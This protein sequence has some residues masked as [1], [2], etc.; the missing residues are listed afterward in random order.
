[1]VRVQVLFVLL[2]LSVAGTARAADPTLSPAKRAEARE[3]YETGARQF[4]IGHYEEAGREFEKA[5]TLLGDP[6]IIYNIAQSYR[7][8][9]KYDLALFFYKSYLRQIPNPKNLDEVERR[10]KELTEIVA[11]QKHASEAPPQT[12][13]KPTEDH[14][15]G[16]P[17]GETTP[18]QP[19]QT[20]PPPQQ[21]QIL[22]PPPAPP[23]PVPR[24]LK[25]LGFAFV[26]VAVVGIALG[27][28]GA[29]IAS[30]SSSDV[31]NAAATNMQ[32]F[33]QA[34]KDK[35]TQGKTFQSVGAA[36]WAIGGLF[37]VGAGVTLAI[38]YR[39]PAAGARAS[40]APV[41]APG[42]AGLVVVG[43]F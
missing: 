35:E 19:P 10:I 37:A 21:P 25:P 29:A 11:Q 20:T 2:A 33:S 26:G 22:A 24:W 36:G 43:R 15:E 34:L 4:E 13:I 17:M 7:L 39:K 30:S 18:K 9:Q 28:A 40:V 1:M 12:T 3:H 42:A 6:V 23:K 14:A 16:T 8:G 41:I 32:M 31:Q 27:A 38:A 5:Y